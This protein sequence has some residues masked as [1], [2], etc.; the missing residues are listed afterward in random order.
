MILRGDAAVHRFPLSAAALSHFLQHWTA[1]L[2]PG[3]M[4]RQVVPRG[5]TTT[6]PAVLA[7]CSD[8]REND[9]GGSR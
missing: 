1:A 9:R 5:I 7:R 8:Q 3:S 6:P 4:A 2:G